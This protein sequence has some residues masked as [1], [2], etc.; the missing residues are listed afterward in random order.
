MVASMPDGERD[1]ITES[2]GVQPVEIDSALVSAC[3]RQRYYWTN[4]PVGR[5]SPLHCMASI[6]LHFQVS[7]DHVGLLHILYFLLRDICIATFRKSCVCVVSRKPF[8]YVS[9][10]SRLL[11]IPHNF[12]SKIFEC[13]SLDELRCTKHLTSLK[14]S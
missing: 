11:Q 13:N 5:L 8:E 6:S 14:D 1:T 7:Y 10:W 2:L 12:S 4:L 9:F 3:H